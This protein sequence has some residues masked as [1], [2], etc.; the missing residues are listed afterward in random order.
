MKS[1]YLIILIEDPRVDSAT[2]ELLQFLFGLHALN[3]D[4]GV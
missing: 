3:K 4:D 1:C 2:K